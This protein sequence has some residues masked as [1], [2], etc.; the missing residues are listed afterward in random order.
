MT[1]AGKA[2]PR[3]KPKACQ[4]SPDS[5]SLNVVVSMQAREA[6]EGAAKKLGVHVSHIVRDALVRGLRKH[7]V[8]L[9]PAEMAPAGREYKK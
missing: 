2:K 7:D 3:P 4:R 8:K 5:S 1:R 9:T 6:I